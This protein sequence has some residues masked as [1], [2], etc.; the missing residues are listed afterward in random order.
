MGVAELKRAREKGALEIIHVDEKKRIYEG[1]TSNF[2]AVMEGQLVTPKG[3]I[4]PGITRAVVLEIADKLSIPY[5]ERNLYLKEIPNF[6][7]AFIT[8]S[9][10]E[11]MPVVQIDEKKV[12]N[13]KVGELTKKLIREFRALTRPY[14]TQGVS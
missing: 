7:E 4:L 9:N 11:I 12:G 13:G 5:E 6:L 14:E 2:F 10:K 8:A 3:R 1:M